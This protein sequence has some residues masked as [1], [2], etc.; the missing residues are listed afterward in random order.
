[1]VFA[2]PP[3]NLDKDYPSG[4]DDNRKEE[5]YLSWCETWLSHC[6]RVLKHGGSLFV[7]N[8]PKWNTY[9]S[10]Y[11][12]NLLNFRHWIA[13]DIT[14]RLPIRG[15]LYPSHYSLLYYCKGKKPKTFNPD[16]T[17]L[18]TCRHCYNDIKDYGGYKRKM[19]PEGK[20]L[21][22]VWYDI[23]P[24]R[25]SKYKN[26]SQGNELSIKLMDRIIEMSTEP[27]DLV[28]DPFGGAGTTYAVSE[29]KNRRWL[30]I[31][32]GPTEAIETRLSDTSDELE[33]LREIRDDLN[34]L[35]PDEVKKKRKKKDIWTDDKYHS[36]NSPD[37]SEGNS[38]DASDRTSNGEGKQTELNLDAE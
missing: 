19:N 29:M 23:S 11:L 17:P 35:F 12:N 32:I 4:I 22:D 28:F 14:Y 34:N 36:N 21:T 15:R 24:V 7:W 18:E 25:H 33:H 16:R 2:D 6:T 27:D 5:E 9:I 3:F 20:S 8:I 26:R 13:T 30:G 31:E 37:S 38:G 1:M 10:R